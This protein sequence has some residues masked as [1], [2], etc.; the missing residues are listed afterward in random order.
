MRR[1]PVLLV[2]AVIVSACGGGGA[3]TPSTDSNTSTTA[4][5]VTTR[6]QPANPTPNVRFSGA[7]ESTSTVSG[8]L[9]FMVTD[10]GQIEELALDAVL[11]NFDC[12]GGMTISSSGAATHFFPDPIV[13]QAGVFS[14]SRSNLDWN[15]E[16]DSATSVHGS[17]RIDAG[18]DCGNRP[19]SVAWTA[20][21]EG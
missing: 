14:V 11:T 10:S 8:T 16:F 13:V 6:P 12:G 3:E 15:G 7:I 17:I 19:P 9:S 1:L 5:T 20:V 21:A 2:I 18:T 4:A